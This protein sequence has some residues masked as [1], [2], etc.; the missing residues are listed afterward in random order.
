METMQ[1]TQA[2][3]FFTDI[4]PLA[5]KQFW[6][7]LSLMKTGAYRYE[8]LTP[9]IARDVQR[10]AEIGGQHDYIQATWILTRTIRRLSSRLEAL[11]H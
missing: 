5:Y 7:C 4:E 3:N 1:R 2:E 11:E 9:D 6:L 8:L 10:A